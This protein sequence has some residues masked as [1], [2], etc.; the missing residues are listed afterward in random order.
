MAPPRSPPIGAVLHYRPRGGGHP[1]E[2]VVMFRRW[3]GTVD[4]DVLS[5]GCSTPLRLTKI[6]HHDKPSACPL[7]ACFSPG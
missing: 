7:G 3:E 6:E 1:C 2:A 4:L 5:P